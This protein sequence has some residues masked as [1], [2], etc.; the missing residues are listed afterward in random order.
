MLYKLKPKKVFYYGRPVDFRKQ[1]IGLACLVDAELPG[2]LREG[3]WFVF[4]ASDKKKVKI[5]YWRGNGLA[6]WHLRLESDNF[7]LGHPRVVDTRSVTWRDLG[8]LLDGLGIFA[9][10]AHAV[11]APKKFS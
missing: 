3:H 10:Q 6:L 9:G 11:T 7:K 2:E 4:F 1:M 8:R 5:L